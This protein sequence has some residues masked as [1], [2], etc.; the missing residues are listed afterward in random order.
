MKKILVLFAVFSLA[1]VIF[2]INCEAKL[3]TIDQITYKTNDDDSLSE[4][5]TGWAK[6]V[7]TGKR[8]YYKNGVRITGVGVVKDKPYIF[9]SDGVY[10]GKYSHKYG[11]KVNFNDGYNIKIADGEISFTV[12]ISDKNDDKGLIYTGH[13]YFSLYVYESGKLI[14]IPYNIEV[15]DDYATP[16]NND[17]RILSFSQPLSNF[18]YNFSPGIY[19]VKVTVS[20]REINEKGYTTKQDENGNLIMYDEYIRAEFNLI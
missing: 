13:P 15:F 2:D 5:Y 9:D 3:K 14:N 1:V 11:Y 4:K 19:R 12:E 16:E 7:S 10:L 18:D 8:Y 17:N 6:S 20:I